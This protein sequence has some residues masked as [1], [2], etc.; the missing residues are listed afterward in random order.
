MTNEKI[1]SMSEIKSKHKRSGG[2]FFQRGSPPVV[3][4]KGN[5]LIAKSYGSGFVLYK[6][7]PKTGHIMYQKEVS[8]KRSF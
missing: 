2:F 6:F 8:S 1:Y 7:N 5:M 4:K 3:A